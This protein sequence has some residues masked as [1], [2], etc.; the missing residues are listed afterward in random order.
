MRNRNSQR[1]PRLAPSKALRAD[2]PR[3]L[4]EV[5]SRPTRAPWLTADG[6]WKLTTAGLLLWAPAGARRWRK[7]GWF[8]S[9]DQLWHG[10]AD[11]WPQECVD[12]V[13]RL[14]LLGSWQQDDERLERRA[15]AARRRRG[16]KPPHPPKRCACCTK[17]FTPKRTDAKCCSGK[18][19]A[20]LSRLV[21]RAME[22]QSEVTLPIV[23]VTGAVPREEP[24]MT[25]GVPLIPRSHGCPMQVYP[26]P[27]VT[28]RWRDV[29]PNAYFCPTT[30]QP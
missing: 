19:R 3:P 14:L 9:G 18:C 10:Q 16:L 29:A 7:T 17:K 26:T 12:E 5:F 4:A 27:G 11:V 15:A 22:K 2:C 20:K 25:L 23:L 8:I 21:R 6:W 13:L 28:G 30:I 1:S 24:P